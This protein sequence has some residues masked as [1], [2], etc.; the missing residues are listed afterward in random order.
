MQHIQKVMFQTVV[1][2]GLGLLVSGLGGCFQDAHEYRMAVGGPQGTTHFRYGC[3]QDAEDA[4]WFMCHSDSESDMGM[5][6]HTAL[7]CE[8]LGYTFEGFMMETPVFEAV[9]GGT[10][11]GFRGEWA[12][13]PVLSPNTSGI[14]EV[15]VPSGNDDIFTNYR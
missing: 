4:D 3:T 10:I 9:S 2:V 12:K 6:V 5:H 8:E 1:L 7:N 14:D 15:R 13:I 11:P